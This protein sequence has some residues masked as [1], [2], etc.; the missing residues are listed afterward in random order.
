MKNK[1]KYRHRHMAVMLADIFASLFL[2]V[3]LIILKAAGVVDMHWALVL[4][5]LVWLSLAMFILTGL[6]WLIGRPFVQLKRWRR[7]RKTDRYIIR[8]AKALG[9]W[10]KPQALG[11]RALELKA[12][13]DFKIKRYPG[14]TDKELRLRYMEGQDNG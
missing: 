12:W 13:Q 8:R 9:V 10:D 1:K 4:S 7:R 14:E 5:S 3:V 2:W 11:G 6:V